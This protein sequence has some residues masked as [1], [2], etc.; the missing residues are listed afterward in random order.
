MLLNT[1]LI[2]LKIVKQLY[3]AFLFLLFQILKFLAID[4]GIY[5]TY[6]L[7]NFVNLVFAAIY[8]SLLNMVNQKGEWLTI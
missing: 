4:Y 3:F 2:L 6:F 7:C 1:S 8:K 5:N